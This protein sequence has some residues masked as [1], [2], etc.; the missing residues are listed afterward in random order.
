MPENLLTMI[1]TG[2][3]YDIINEKSKTTLKKNPNT[4]PNKKM[5]TPLRTLIM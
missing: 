1:V 5:P 3:H 2:N 4:N